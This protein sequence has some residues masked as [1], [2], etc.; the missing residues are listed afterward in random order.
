MN[1]I[2]TSEQMR[3][4]ENQAAHRGLS[5][6]VLAEN[7][8][9]ACFNYL[10]DSVSN[11]RSRSVTVLCGA[12]MNGGDGILI[13]SLLR[14]AGAEVLSVFVS[15]IKHPLAREIYEEVA[16]NLITTVY[17]G[18]EDAVK[19]TLQSSDIIIDCVFGTG[20]EGTLDGRIADLFYF[21]NSGCDGY[22]VSA[23]IPS[24]VNADTGEQAEHSF[25]PDTTLILGAYKKGLLRHPTRDWC[26]DYVLLDIGLTDNDCV[27]CEAAFTDSSILSRRP[28]RSPTSHKGSFGKLLNIA[29]SERYIGAA[30]LSAKAAVRSG[31]GLVTLAAPEAVISAVAHAVPEAVFARI[32]GSDKNKVFT[33]EL[34]AATAIT[35][36][37]GLGNSSE[38][39]KITEFVIKNA[40]C[41]IILDADGIN[42]ISDNINVLQAMPVSS[43]PQLILTPHPGEFARLTGLSVAEI[44]SNRIDYTRLFAKESGA[45]VVLK[46]VNTVI[47]SPCGAVTVNPTGNAG[48]AKAG[49]GDV[50]TGIIGALAA[51]GMD[52][53]E[54]AALGV[55][56]HGAAADNLAL[57][58]P[59]SRITASDI[60]ENIP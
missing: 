40:V 11:I 12:G 3:A 14:Q 8:A 22:K 35:L 54:A 18:N 31:A 19:Y 57:T 9:S 46:G 15:D 47:A 55:Y 13:S 33:G 43:V 24:G 44:Q 2:V 52:L 42:S 56:L 48:L 20:F 34:K 25:I 36:G 37:C 1:A 17:S 38:T 27:S 32:D 39:R 45:I 28:K 41:P 58:A 7:A 6:R 21:V 4:A 26:G 53:F 49:T 23:D 50:L 10:N 29:G 5:L 16:P 51:Q 60:I 30:L 59:L